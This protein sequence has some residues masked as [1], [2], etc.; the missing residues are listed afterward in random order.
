L[1]TETANIVEFPIP[2][3]G[4]WK[5]VPMAIAAGPD[6]NL[7]FI[8]DTRNS[9]ARLTTA[10]E[11]TEFPIPTGDDWANR[12][13]PESIVAG[14]DGNLWFTEASGNMI[15]RISTAGEITEFTLPIL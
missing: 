5:S 6:G 8:S 14:L 15:G 4:L 3:I 1:R 10:G 12:S 9:I 7:W 13:N 11:V 2:M